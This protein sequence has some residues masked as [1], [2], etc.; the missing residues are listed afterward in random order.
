[1]TTPAANT[2]FYIL[3]DAYS[4]AKLLQDG[5]VLSPDQL[6][7]GM[8]K[9]NDMINVWM[10]YP[11]LKLWLNVDTSVTLVTAQ[12]AYTLGPSGSVD[13]T[14][15]L[16]VI[17][18]Y[19]L[20]DQTPGNSRPITVLSWNEYLTLG[21]R[22]QSG[23]ISSIFVDKGQ[24]L[25]RVSVWPVPDATTA[26]GTLHLLLQTQVTGP[27]S[28]IETMNFPIEWRIAL[29]WGM[30]AEVCTG[31]PQ[32]VVQ[33]CEQRAE[34]YRSQLEGWDVEDVATRFTPSTQQTAYGPSGQFR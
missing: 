16:R 11:G 31:Q 24:V 33:R 2:P 15:P 34:M 27:I 19:Y 1:M 4:E 22:D 13:M 23:A 21:Q 7:Y 8:R 20:D 26:L 18:A 29:V 28:L 17:Q 30:A 12:K 14:R 10:A 6:A 25:M 5:D 32:S 3:Q 9:L